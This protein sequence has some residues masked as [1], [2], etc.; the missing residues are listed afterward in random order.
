MLAK[1][2]SSTPHAVHT[3]WKPVPRGIFNVICAVSL[4]LS[5]AACLAWARGYWRADEFAAGYWNYRPHPRAAGYYDADV[6]QVV[7]CNGRWTV[8]VREQECVITPHHSRRGPGENGERWTWKAEDAASAVA[9][10]EAEF[11][12]VARPD[13][14]LGF[15][16]ESTRWSRTAAFPDAAP[17]LA[18]ALLPLAWLLTR[19]RRHGRDRSGLCRVCGY[20]LRATPDRCPECGASPAGATK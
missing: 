1:L 6:L 14:W 16:R 18:F 13:G 20:D 12:D 9:G 3:G 17:T 15:A 11:W 7:H 8:A 5:T 19:G 2:I 10:G 4:V